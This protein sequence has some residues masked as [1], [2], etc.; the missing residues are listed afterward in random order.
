MHGPSGCSRATLLRERQA[1]VDAR[2]AAGCR[3]DLEISSSKRDALLH[4]KQA[5]A[6]SLNGALAR[7]GHIEAATVIAYHELQDAVGLAEL[8]LDEVRLRVTD[9]I[10]QRLLR[11]AK[12]G[13]L[14][15][16]RR[17]RPEGS[18]GEAE[19]ESGAF[20]LVL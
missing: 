4:A 1:H 18:D 17:P 8:D 15:G 11:D 10:G 3:V 12:A 6:S 19:G 16:G 7:G 13:H 2:A 9:D 5:L 14:H 20:R